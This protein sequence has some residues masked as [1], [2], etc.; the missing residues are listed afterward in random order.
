MTLESVEIKLGLLC[1]ACNTAIPINGIMPIAKCPACLEET[2]IT[3]GKFR[4]D[5]LLNYKNPP[6]SVF[7]AMAKVKTGA[8][9]NGAWVPVKL[10]TK[11]IAPTCHQCKQPIQN[12]SFEKLS[13]TEKKHTIKCTTAECEAS[14]EVFAVPEYFKKIF[15]MALWVVGGN[16]SESSSPTSPPSVATKPV[17][18]ACMACGGSLKADGS[19][20]IVECEFCKSNNFLPDALWLFLHPRPKME[21]WYIIYKEF[22]I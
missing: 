1:P 5:E 15:S 8:I 20:R 9:E 13:T 18:L 2:S 11:K 19:S 6:W 14:I 4:W 21:P 12:Q 22:K 7:K 3:E 10:S 17:V 16:V